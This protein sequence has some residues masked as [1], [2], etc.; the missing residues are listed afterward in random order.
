MDTPAARV[1]PQKWREYRGIIIS[2]VLADLP[3]SYQS[4]F[5]KMNVSSHNMHQF[6]Y[7]LDIL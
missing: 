1:A 7:D 5:I 4:V 2:T 6:I 3:V